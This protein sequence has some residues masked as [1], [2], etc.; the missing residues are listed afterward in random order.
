MVIGHRG[1]ALEAPANTITAVRHAIRTADAVEIDVHRCRDGELVVFHDERLDRGTD[2][3]G[4]VAETACDRVLDAE[5]GDSGETVPTLRAVLGELP[6]EFKGYMDLKTPDIAADA[7][8]M[9]E[10]A[11]ANV[12]LSS[13]DPDIVREARAAAPTVPRALIVRES[14]RNRPLR[15]VIPGAPGRLYFSED[16]SA[17]V[18]RAIELDCDAIHPR[19]ELCLR[20]DLVER[21]HA[22]G[23]RVEAWTVTSQREYDALGAVGVDA[24]I[25]DRCAGLNR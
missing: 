11:N 24:V 8:A 19:Y 22:A 2:V 7:V 9:A 17:T 14:R 5:V 23:L 16:V 25:S 4:A 10:E 21:A 1:C 18:D 3:T 15:S 12:V 20:T 13:F 6:P